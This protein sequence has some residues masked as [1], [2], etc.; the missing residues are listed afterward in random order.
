MDYSLR[1]KVSAA[2]STLAL[3]LGIGTIAYHFLE[4]WTWT[5]SFYFSVVTLS[6]VGYGNLYPT[7]AASQLFTSFYI[8]IGVAAVVSSLGIIGSAILDRRETK[9]MKRMESRNRARDD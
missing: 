4:G 3:F 1:F 7:T 5:T 2:L 9:L 8:L 6:T